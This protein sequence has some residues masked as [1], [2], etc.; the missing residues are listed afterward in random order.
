M[1]IIKS[2]KS[3]KK[4][5]KRYTKSGKNYL[6]KCAKS[7]NNVKSTSLNIYMRE[8]KPKYAIRISAKNFGYENNI[9]SIPLYAAFCIE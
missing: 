7:G 4:H 9:K 3:G 2:A 6:E 8:N 1:K 5:L